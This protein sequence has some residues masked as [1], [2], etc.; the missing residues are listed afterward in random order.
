MPAPEWTL[1]AGSLTG[2]GDKLAGCHIFNNTT[3]YT[4][5]KP[6]PNEVLAT[7]SGT[8]LPVTFPTFSYKN[9]NLWS[10]TVSTAPDGATATGSWSFPAQPGAVDPG[11][12]GAESGTYTAQT[13]P[14]LWEGE[15]EEASS[16]SA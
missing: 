12:I 3:N 10:V 11:D 5:T 6:N 14:G 8:T 16:A 4:L 13:G 7:S 1:N 2:S 9:I 15:E